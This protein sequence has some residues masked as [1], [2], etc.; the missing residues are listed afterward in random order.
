MRAVLVFCEGSHDV[1]FTQRSLGAVAQCK[2]VS[3]SIRQL[4]SPFGRSPTASKGL[5]ATRLE[6]RSIEDL[7]L[8]MATHP[9]LPSFEA[10]VEDTASNTM[11]M[12]IRTNGKDQVETV[13]NLLIDL[14]D[15]FDE[16]LV[17][18][19]D[20][21]EYAAAFLFDANAIGTAATIDD[22]RQRY[23]NHFG[24]LSGVDHG[25][26]DTT[27]ISPVGCF[28]FHDRSGDRTGTLED[29]LA[30]MVDTEWP[31]RYAKAHVFIDNNMEE[32]DKVYGSRASQLK[33]VITA[34]GQFRVPGAGLTQVIGRGGLPKAVF[35]ES[36]L[37]KELVAFLMAAPWAG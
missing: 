19:Y 4:P 12:L 23:D 17:D 22:F 6:R 3:K 32:S 31:D 1:A 16:T 11:F 36:S 10:I 8:Q 18:T 30:P 26:W 13:Q 21:A 24:D 25:T 7:N 33:A 27:E 5:L 34:A 15:T 9:P 20:V 28:V 35:E 2:W 37:S 29:Q 14:R